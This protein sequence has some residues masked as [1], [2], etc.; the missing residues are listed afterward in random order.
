MYEEK[1]MKHKSTTQQTLNA[2]IEQRDNLSLQEQQLRQTNLELVLQQHVLAS[3]CDVLHLMRTGEVP[4]WSYRAAG[5]LQGELP[6]L[7]QLG[8]T[9][10]STMEL[11]LQRLKV[12][13]VALES[14]QDIPCPEPAASSPHEAAKSGGGAAAP[15]PLDLQQQQ[16]QLKQQQLG[17]QQGGMQ[18]QQVAAA[19]VSQAASSPGSQDI[20]SIARPATAS[21]APTTTYSPK[22]SGQLSSPT[23]TT[24]PA[25]LQ[26]AAA[27]SQAAA[28][29][30]D[31]ASPVNEREVRVA[32]PADYM[33]AFRQL[34][35]Q[36]PVPGASSMTL[37]DFAQ[38]YSG[39]V[40]EAALW[41]SLVQQRG[42]QFCTA[43]SSSSSSTIRDPMSAL[44]ALMTYH[45]RVFASLMLL[46]GDDM[47]HK[48]RVLNCDSLDTQDAPEQVGLSFVSSG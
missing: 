14:H 11:Q 9:P 12:C 40:K 8:V 3:C 36:P 46:P 29:A 22:D 25:A 19:Q 43:D 7:L 6:L 31:A 21:T 27:V 13:C 1:S 45:G 41:L 34:M 42:P 24:P 23:G 15:Q 17:Q 33:G 35:T 47:L 18:L 2:L 38:Y 32:V 16:Q 26:A 30:S 44:A 37:Q 4:G 5:V 28:A 48:I 20:R 39:Y 10:D